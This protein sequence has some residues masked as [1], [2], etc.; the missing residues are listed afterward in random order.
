MAQ[1]MPGRGVLAGVRVVDFTI[2][3]PGPYATQLLAALG[4]D[5]CKVEPPGG[6][7]MRAYPGL[8]A[9]LSAGKRTMELDLK[10]P[11][12]TGLDVLARLQGHRD[13]PPVVMM[14]GHGT[15][16][17]AVKATRLGAVDFLEKPIEM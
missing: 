10:L 3:R 4:A 13:A 12:M 9:E 11:D 8:F 15:L 7:P 1:S 6:D 16:D 5:V 17:A 14:S 2:W